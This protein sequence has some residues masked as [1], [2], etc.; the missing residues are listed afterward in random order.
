MSSLHISSMILLCSTEDGRSLLL[1]TIFGS[2]SEI[3]KKTIAEKEIYLFIYWFAERKE[4]DLLEH[5][6]TFPG[7]KKEAEK[8]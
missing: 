7:Q 5:L 3:M 4:K 2:V 6:P 1:S 8:M